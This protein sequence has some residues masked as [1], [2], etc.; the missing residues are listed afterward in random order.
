VQN[1]DEFNT[2]WA[3][4]VG[5]DVGRAFDHEF[6]GAGD[7][8]RPPCCRMSNQQCR[9]GTDPE[10][11]FRCCYRVIARDERLDFVEVGEREPAPQ[12]L[13]ACSTVSS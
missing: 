13:R 3:S 7:A 9:R 11:Q 2:A 4:A 6:S 1:A 5:N 8:A 10:D 12:Y